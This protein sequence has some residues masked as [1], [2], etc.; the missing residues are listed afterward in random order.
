MQFDCS[1]TKKQRGATTLQA[2]AAVL[3]GTNSLHTNSLDEAIALPTEETARLA[4]R[5]QQILAYENGI[6]DIADP[7]GGSYLLETLTKKLE[8]ES[9]NYFD[10]IDLLGGMIPAI[11]KGFPQKEIQEASYQYQKTIEK[12]DETI[13]GVNEF[14]TEDKMYIELLQI[15]SGVQE[16]QSKRLQNLRRRRNSRDVNN[17][18]SDIKQTAISSKNLIPSLI[19][20]ARAYVTVGEMVEVLSET[21]GIYQEPSF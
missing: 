20:A 18:L 8:Q 11:E 1:T 3:G 7:L 4:L 2:L 15:G 13:V 19:Q 10:T 16:H 5:T 6:R 12:G 21:F 14:L 17:A 9:H